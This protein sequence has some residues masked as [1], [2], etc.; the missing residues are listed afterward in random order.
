M[1]ALRESE[2]DFQGAVMDLARI[3]GWRVAHFHDSR[4]Q[5]T[6][7]GETQLVGDKDAAGFPDLVLLRAPF[8]LLFAELKSLRGRL[9][10][11]Q[12]EWV[13]DLSAFSSMIAAMACTRGTPSRPTVETYLWTP[14]DWE[15]IKKRLTRA[16]R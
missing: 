12:A 2:R 8:E 9:R 5:V 4:R 16:A 1:S 13:D 10:P 3:C 15:T 7:K 11:E 14:A 6:R